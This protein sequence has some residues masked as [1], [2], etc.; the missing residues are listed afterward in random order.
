M[1]RLQARL[2][3]H[4]APL[5]GPCVGMLALRNIPK[6]GR[7]ADDLLA[8]VHLSLPEIVQAAETLTRETGTSDSREARRQRGTR[9]H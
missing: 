4:V 1:V 9:H 8:F 2:S 3:A 5:C 7:T 6:S